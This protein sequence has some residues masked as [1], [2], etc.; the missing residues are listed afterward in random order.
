[1]KRTQLIKPA[2]AAL[3]LSASI[4]SAQIPARYAND[5]VVLRIAE[6]L[7]TQ[8]FE[9]TEVS[10][11]LLGRYKIE[12]NAPGYN[13]E[14]VYAPGTNTVLKDEWQESAGTGS[15]ANVQ[16]PTETSEPLEPTEIVETPEPEDPVE[17]V[18]PPE[19][20]DPVEPVEPPE[21]VETPEPETG[22][23]GS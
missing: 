17:V 16:E 18:E 15:G 7:A 23:S 5:P 20:E 1:M 13:R 22:E 2:A 12:A 10:I 19:P 11:T 8:G 3:L 4:A 21:P 9:I 6:Q 14:I